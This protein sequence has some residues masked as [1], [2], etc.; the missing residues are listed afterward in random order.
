MKKEAE[1]CK[2]CGAVRRHKNSCRY[3]LRIAQ[4][5]ANEGL[6]KLTD[7]QKKELDEY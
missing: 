6:L 2:Y 7:E 1:P 5:L 4:G 3:I